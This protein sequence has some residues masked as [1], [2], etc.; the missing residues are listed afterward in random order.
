MKLSK[1]G[2]APIAPKQ[3]TQGRPGERSQRASKEN[4]TRVFRRTTERTE[5]IGRA[6]S[7]QDLLARRQLIERQLPR[8][9]LNLE[10]ARP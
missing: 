7:G 10:R 2:R 4:V 6:M 5:A 9:D 1:I 8:E 3:L